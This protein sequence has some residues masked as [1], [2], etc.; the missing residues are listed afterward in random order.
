VPSYPEGGTLPAPSEPWTVE[1]AEVMA[2]A[3]LDAA[4]DRIQPFSERTQVEVLLL[5]S[6]AASSLAVA[7][8]TK[9]PVKRG[10]KTT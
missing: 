7:K 9:A 1:D 2:E 4:M 3:A 8:K 6:I 5:A 10:G